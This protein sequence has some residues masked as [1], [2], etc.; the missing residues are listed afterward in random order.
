M[1]ELLD[2]KEIHSIESR[3]IALLDRTFLKSTKLD[4]VDYKKELPRNVKRW[5]GSKTFE[6]QLDNLITEL[7]KFSLLYA[8]SQMKI[9]TAATVEEGTIL[10]KEAIARATDIS[11]TASKSIIKMLEDDAIYYEGPAKLGRRIE[12]LWQGQRWKAVSFAHTFSADVATATT[13][14]RYRQYG[15]QF[16]EFSA[17][18]DERTTDQCRCLNKTV[19]DLSKQSVDAYRPPLHHRCRSALLPIPNTREPQK[20]M[21]FEN[22]DFSGTLDDPDAVKKV[23]KDIEKF[24]DKYRVSGYVIDKDLST[25]I[26]L[27]KGVSVGIDKAI[28]KLSSLR[29]SEAVRQKVLT[30][31]SKYGTKREQLVKD[32][33][34]MHVRNKE[35]FDDMRMSYAR[36]D[37]YEIGSNEYN[38]ITQHIDDIDNEMKQVLSDFEKKSKQLDKLD[39]KYKSKLHEHMYLR[40]SPDIAVTHTEYV[41]DIVD[42]DG[43]AKQAKGMIEPTK[44]HLKN[45]RDAMEFVGKITSKDKFDMAFKPIIRADGTQYNPVTVSILPKGER[46]HATFDAIHI[47]IGKESATISHELGHLLEISDRDIYESAVSMRMKYATAKETK[48]L[49]DITGDVYY[50]ENEVAYVGNYPSAYMGKVYEQEA[51]EM[52]SMGIELLYRDPAGFARD[53]PEFFNWILG[54]LA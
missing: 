43:W 14:Y 27:E 48:K 32:I 6:L 10:T 28:P 12:D 53:Y 30:E 19:F 39:A 17:K 16:M 35:L 8:D 33:D 36:R 24:N 40:E 2:S 46:A 11:E 41:Y 20:D 54:V 34:S 50:S 26:M 5:F 21:V 13:V 29:D 18:L 1:V 52:V 37:V 51:T 22:R 44:A 42:K 15:V 45:E 4:S 31:Y 7:I 38:A 9:L 47:P 49:A 3:M 25:R 23:F